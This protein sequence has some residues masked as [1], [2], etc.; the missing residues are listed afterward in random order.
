M[1][2]GHLAMTYTALAVLIILGDD[3]K[4]VDRASISRGL[5]KLQNPDGSFTAS[6]EASENDMRFVYC[7]CAVAYMIGTI[8]RQFLSN[9][10][11]TRPKG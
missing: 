7:A 5:A 6:L 10:W 3:L 4:R 9:Q 8:Y 2:G 11:D 1:D